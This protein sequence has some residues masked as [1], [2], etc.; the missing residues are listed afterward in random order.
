[1][2]DYHVVASVIGV[3][4]ELASMVPYFRNIFRGT[5][6]PHA[7]TWLGWGLI[8]S[9]VG[10]AQFISGAG[11]SVYVSITVA[12]MCFAVAALALVW[13]EK[14]ITKGDWVCLGG[15]IFAISLWYVTS[16]PLAAVVIVTIA[17]VLAFIPTYRKAYYRPHEET[18]LTFGIGAIRNVFA[19]AAL[20]S[21]AVVNW[22]YPASLIV[23]DGAFTVMLLLRRRQMSTGDA[24]KRS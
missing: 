7:F 22:L 17:D 15:S 14:Q 23:T 18:A 16:N 20:Q 8:N 4:L 24:A 13:G 1:M 21:L 9:I 12:L 3:I 19:I 5:T 10:S 6:K 2:Y 11:P